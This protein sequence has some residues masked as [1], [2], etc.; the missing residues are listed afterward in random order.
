MANGRFERFSFSRASLAQG[1]DAKPLYDAFMQDVEQ[2]Y[3]NNSN[4][5]AISYDEETTELV[6]SN[7]FV[8][9][10]L[11]ENLKSSNLRTA[12]PSDDRYGDIFRLIKGKF[13]VDL[14]AAILRTAGD[15]YKPND[16]IAKDL[17]EKIEEK[18]RK[19]KLP[20]MVVSPVV[21]YLPEDK[22]YALTF[23]LSEDS[24][25][26]QDE[27]LDGK[28]YLYMKFNEVDDLGLPIF[29]KEG[30]RTWHAREDGLSRLIFYGDSGLNSNNE[31][32]AISYDNG[33]VV[34]VRGEAT[35]NLNKEQIEKSYTME[36]IIKALMI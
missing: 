26:I 2:N 1:E 14:N 17:A 13:Y 7:I 18:E 8:V 22:N 3:G 24:L 28:K 16:K 34:L 20:V 25:I 12:I 5:R 30:T 36:D 6:G 15:S 10:R 11:S 4:L 27:R 29:D 9:S 31:L 35:Q 23:S 19:L 32:L 33:R 21:R